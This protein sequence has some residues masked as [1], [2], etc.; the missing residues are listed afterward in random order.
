MNNI[1]NNPLCLEDYK[2]NGVEMNAV[3][4]VETDYDQK[5]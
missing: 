3:L 1:I 4:E 5:I 2:L